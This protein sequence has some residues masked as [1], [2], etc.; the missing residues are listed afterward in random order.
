MTKAL[1]SLAAISL[2]ALAACGGAADRD[3]DADDYAARIAGNDAVGQNAPQGSVAP[4]VQEVPE[5]GAPGP[6]TPGTQTDPTSACNA[7]KIGTYLGKLADDA[8]RA[9]I[10]NV[11]DGA[12]EVRFIAPGPTFINPDPTNPRL[13]I[14]LDKQ[15]IIRDA[16]CG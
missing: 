16:R 7:P 2:L 9:E 15:G 13:N 1:P 6:F 14:M 3:E 11:I 5:G 4:Q 12:N 10:M 8:T